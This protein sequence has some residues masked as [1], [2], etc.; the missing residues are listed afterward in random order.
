MKNAMFAMSVWNKFDPT[1]V[2]KIQDDK[3]KSKFSI[4]EIIRRS[5]VI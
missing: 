5:K 3:L 4:E 2:D 1:V